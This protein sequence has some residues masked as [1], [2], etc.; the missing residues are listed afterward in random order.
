MS[1]TL[2][3]DRATASLALHVTL[4]RRALVFSLRAC[5]FRLP[6]AAQHLGKVF[7]L[8]HRTKVV[9]AFM[10]LSCASSSTY[11]ALCGSPQNLDINFIRLGA[12]SPS[13]A[14][15]V[16]FLMTFSAVALCD[17]DSRGRGVWAEGGKR[18]IQSGVIREMRLGKKDATRPHANVGQTIYM[19]CVFAAEIMGE[20]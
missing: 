19:T 5:N 1:Y 2:S 10:E 15:F 14:A 6:F 11:T 8:N 18:V 16:S 9:C 13:E 17:V 7:L 4:Q 3:S 12:L 20:D